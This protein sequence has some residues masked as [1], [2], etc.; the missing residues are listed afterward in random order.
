MAERVIDNIRSELQNAILPEMNWLADELNKLGYLSSRTYEDIKSSHSVLRESQMAGALVGDVHRRA[1]LDPDAMG[2]FLRI[3]EKKCLQLQPAINL[4]RPA[5]NK[6][7][8][9]P[10]SYPL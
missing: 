1:Q 7:N 6:H 9:S 3:L 4:L 10:V 5:G 8:P 2:E